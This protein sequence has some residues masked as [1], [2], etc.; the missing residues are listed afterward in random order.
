MF[1][2]ASLLAV[3]LFAAT[4]V[5][6]SPRGVWIPPDVKG[7]RAHQLLLAPGPRA[8][9]SFSNTVQPP[10]RVQVAEPTAAPIQVTIMLPPTAQPL[11]PSGATVA[12]KGPDGK[13]RNFPVEG[14]RKT[15][16]S[17][18]IVV[19]PGERATIRFVVGRR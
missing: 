14:G 5:A 3:S 9:S 19:H 15:L 16:E 11:E 2:T 18:V 4:A 13:I 7:Y 17:R 10:V 8:T 12:I 1:R 6:Q